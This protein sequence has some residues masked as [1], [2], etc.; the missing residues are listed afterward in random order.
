MKRSIRPSSVFSGELTIPASKSH[1]QRVLACAL[2][3]EERTRIH[4]LGDSD[5]EKAAL[6]LLEQS[7]FPPSLKDGVLEVPKGSKL[8][9]KDDEL[10]FGESGLSSR[11]FTPILANG[12]QRLE[13]NGR[14]SLQSRPMRLFDE[15]FP[16]LNVDF[17]STNGT[18]PF[19]LN[20]PLI[21]C[22]I[23]LDGSLSSQFITGFIYAYAGNQRTRKE[24]LRILKPAS[25]PYIELSLDVL[26]E[27]GVNIEF[28][29]HEVRFNGPYQFNDT[30]L[31]I[32]GD[33]SSASFLLVA[34]AIF[35]SVRVNG[36][37]KDS[38]QADIRLIQ[39]LL[40]FGAVVNWEG[41]SLVVVKNE[42]RSFEF[43]ATHCPDLFPPLAVLAS[44]GSGVS[45]V[46][47]VHRLFTKESNRAVTIVEELTK[48]GARIAVE[49]DAMIIQ[50]R[51]NAVSF[52]VSSR[53]DHR[54]AMASAVF[55]L[56]LNAAVNITDAEAV[57]K[58]FPEF[59]TYFEQL[60][61]K[62]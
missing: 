43:D 16:K 12:E 27:F 32:E 6:S 22:S 41:E 31:S 26:R 25:V 30:E 11:M 19:S 3:S 62:S 54:I 8:Q 1:A 46:S 2:I 13:L 36:L 20:G 57:N 49:E 23:E 14:G 48:L 47:G 10:S 60:S 15:V 38:K 53:H 37:R 4:G 5:D 18:L 56:G 35:G 21:P 51:Q 33:W 7:V 55:A 44:Y 39:A 50:P 17:K 58:S 42:H 40:D 28:D 45:R 52:E 29:G 34:A 59:Y 61:L 9:F 24:T